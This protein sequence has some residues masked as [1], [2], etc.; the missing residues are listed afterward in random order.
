M[1]FAFPMIPLWATMAIQ[2][3]RVPIMEHIASVEKKQTPIFFFLYRSLTS[4]SQVFSKRNEMKHGTIVKQ[5]IPFRKRHEMRTIRWSL[6]TSNQL[7]SST[8]K[9]D[10]DHQP[11][12]FHCKRRNFFER[13]FWRSSFTPNV[14]HQTWRNFLFCLSSIAT[15]TV[16]TGLNLNGIYAWRRCVG[17]ASSSSFVSYDVPTGTLHLFRTD[18]LNSKKFL[19]WTTSSLGLHVI[20]AAPL[21][22]SLRE[23]DE[24]SLS[25]NLMFCSPITSVWIIIQQCGQVLGVNI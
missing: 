17:L 18:F 3:N 23:A 14:E 1:W 4:H 15:T 19:D 6:K 25:T 20:V 7:S 10:G 22:T 21:L 5:Y 2:R 11:N 8:S 16:A 13:I 12:R 9:R 24:L